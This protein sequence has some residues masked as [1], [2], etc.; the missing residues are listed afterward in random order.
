M[1]FLS[2]VFTSLK[3]PKNTE[4]WIIVRKL[5]IAKVKYTMTTKYNQVTLDDAGF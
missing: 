1:E 5:N 2:D 3:I 4:R